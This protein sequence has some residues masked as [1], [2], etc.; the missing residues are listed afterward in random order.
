VSQRPF[1][2]I[3]IDATGFDLDRNLKFTVNRMKMGR[4]MITLVHG[5]D[6]AE[7]AT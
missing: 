4:S 3:A 6:D 2:E 1:R 5:D 7:K